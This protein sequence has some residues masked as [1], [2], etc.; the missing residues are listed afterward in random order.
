M[1]IL[2]QGDSVTDAGR[3]RSD[4]HD[5]GNGYPR[6]ASAMMQDSFSDKEFEFVNLGISGNRT[7]H[8]VERLEADF[9]EIQPDIVS[10]LIGVNDV[11]HHYSHGI[12]TSD[13]QFEKNYRVVLDALKTRTN[14][15]ILMIQ[16]FLLETVDPAKQAYTEELA[17]KQAIVK[18]LADE[19]ADA[20]LPLDEILHRETEEEPAYYAADGVHPTP[21]GACYIGEAY[22]GAIAP[23]I[24]LLS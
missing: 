10:I 12:E 9:I 8:L 22:L 13:E 15:R 11:W 5:M 7:E 3:D 19:Y 14:A 21:D 1:K 18:Q 16:P 23:L 6:Y 4:P 2:F 17:R 24:E 20:Y